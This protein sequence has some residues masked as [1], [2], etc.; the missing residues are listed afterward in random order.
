MADDLSDDGVGEEGTG[1]LLAAS[2]TGDPTSVEAFHAPLGETDDEW[3][4]P[5]RIPVSPTLHLDGFDGPMDLLL[6]LAERQRIDF[7][8]LSILDLA[9]QFV[10]ALESFSSRVPLERRAD[11]LVLATRLVLLRS[12]LLFPENPAAARAAAAEIGR[13]EELVFLR[14]AGG[15]L[16]DRPQLGI[17]TFAPPH[18]EAPREGGYVAL[19]EA[20]LTVLRWSPHTAAE[21]PVYAPTISDLWRVSDAMLRITE[22]LAV[23]PEGW[24]LAAFLP[25]I[26]PNDQNRRVRVRTAV[27]STLLASLELA[28]EGALILEQEVPMAEVWLRYDLDLAEARVGPSA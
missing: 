2:V 14:A 25:P 4:G 13:L 20:C 26:A 10:A 1:R 27:A 28:R 19:M 6:D 16:G 24:E 15:W 11:W 23:H 21:A 12:R 3:E 9:E 8:R 5:E 7:G 18:T 17:D 22:L